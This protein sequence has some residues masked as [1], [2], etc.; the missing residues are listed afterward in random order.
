V[1]ALSLHIGLN[2]VDNAVYGSVPALQNCINDARSMSNLADSLGYETQV[3]T[4][5]G[6][7][8]KEVIGAINAAAKKLS[9]GDIFLLSYAGHGSQVPDITADESDGLDETWCLYDRMLLD[10]ELYALWG[11]FNAGVRIVVVSDSCHSG[12]IL[13]GWAGELGGN[14][15]G[16]PP[17]FRTIPIEKAID[18]FNALRAIYEPIKAITGGKRGVINASVLQLAACQD[19]QL[20]SDGVGNGFFTKNLLD[21]WKNGSYPS[22]YRSFLR[23]IAEKMASPSQIPQFEVTGALNSGFEAQTPFFVSD[24]RNRN[25]TSQMMD[26]TIRLDREFVRSATIQQLI[27][28]LK[29]EGVDALADVYPKWVA[30]L[31][32]LSGLSRGEWEVAVKSEPK[33]GNTSIEAKIKGT[34]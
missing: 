28:T 27:E 25:L 7:T 13:R 8:S 23:G 12:T 2:S 4:D 11:K 29:T 3:L 16:G 31:P 1:Q 20:S 18:V 21:V 14:G 30:S 9:S 19:Q 33:T 24:A 10:D 5:S 22:N 15:K 34:F 32:S 17:P 6:A 26:F